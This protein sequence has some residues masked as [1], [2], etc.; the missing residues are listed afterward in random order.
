MAAIE[1]V[2]KAVEGITLVCTKCEAPDADLLHPDGFHVGLE[3]V[4]TVD[5][6]PLHLRGRLRA[7]SDAIRAELVA[8]GTTGV[9]RIYYD[10]DEMGEN[11][12]MWNRSIPTRLA[13]FFENRRS[14][15]RVQT[16]DLRAQQIF[17]IVH[18]D[19]EQ[20]DRTFV[21]VGW[22]IVTRQGETLADVT[23]ASKNAK[24]AKYRQINGAR[25]HQYW[26]AIA[27]IGPGTV[28]D[29]GYSL[30]LSRSFQT[31]YDRVFLIWHGS[32]G[33]YERAEEITPLR[34]E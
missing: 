10:L 16:A 22:S 32:N 29:G 12:K 31:D 2:V 23:L 17:G 14:S 25:F 24:L 18:I 13:Q 26:L 6:R 28:E 19:V 1:C 30:L 15:G 20:A 3:I 4:Q 8:R 9:Y 21:G 34:R 11:I 27:S 33:R 5:P 7:A